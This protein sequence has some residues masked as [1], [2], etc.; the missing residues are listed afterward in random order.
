MS[1]SY[2]G[3]ISSSNVPALSQPYQLGSLSK[4]KKM[5]QRGICVISLQVLQMFMAT[6]IIRNALALGSEIS[7]QWPKTSG[8]Q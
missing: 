1:P 8:A 4:G 5:R 7:C 2:V 3:N 6:V